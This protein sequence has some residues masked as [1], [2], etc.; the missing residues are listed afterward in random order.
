MPTCI[1]KATMLA[2]TG[3]LVL[4][5]LSLSQPPSSLSQVNCTA[6]LHFCKCI[7][8]GNALEAPVEGQ[9]GVYIRD[10]FLKI[11]REAGFEA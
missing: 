2:L 6:K 5:P 7:N 9:W 3:I 10:E 4:I 1:S 8:I 11:I